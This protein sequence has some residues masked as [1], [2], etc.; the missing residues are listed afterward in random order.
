MELTAY[1]FAQGAVKVRPAPLERDWMDASTDRFAYRC[2]PLNIANAHGWEMLTPTGFKATWNGRPD[3]DAIRVYPFRGT[4]APAISHFG[5]GVLT[6]HVMCL[7]R[8]E[9]GYDL[10]V[11]GPVNRPKDAIAPLTGIIETDWAPYTFTMNWMFTRPGTVVKFEP[12]EPFCHFFPVKRGEVE[13]FQPRLIPLSANVELQQQYDAWNISRTKF[14]E[15]VKVPG[16]AAREEKWQK[17]YY[18]GLDASG[19]EVKSVD[20]RTRLRVKPFEG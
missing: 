5:S 4:E 12:G 10:L 6:F 14:N 7:F 9:P 17:L 1:T 19:R 8:T 3:I 20:H 18:R 16:S 11:Q 13:A 2:L 15:E